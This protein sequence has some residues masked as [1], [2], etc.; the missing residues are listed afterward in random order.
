MKR[1]YLWFIAV[2]VIVLIALAIAGRH[3]QRVE[4]VT[5]AARAESARCSQVGQAFRRHL[6]GGWL[7]M[8][9][10]VLRI[11]PDSHGSSTHQRFILVCKSRQTVLIDNNV[12]IGRRVPLHVGERVTV[13][14]Q[15]ILNNLG[16]LI[17]DTHHAGV[18]SQNGWIFA[19]GRVYQ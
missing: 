11:L 4:S 5:G 15:Y 1:S 14:G 16:G 17:H 7:T 2:T 8:S 10:S 19:G 3:A 18:F 9:G 13:H 12:D 6:S